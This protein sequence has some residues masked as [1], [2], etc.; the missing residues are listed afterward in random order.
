VLHRIRE[1][2]RLRVDAGVAQRA[3]EEATG[4]SD[5]RRALPILDVTGLSPIIMIRAAR[6]PAPKTV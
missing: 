6:G 3:M 4:R 1:I 5:E 2:Q